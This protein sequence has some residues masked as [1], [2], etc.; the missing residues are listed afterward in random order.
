MNAENRSALVLGAN[1]GQADLIRYLGEQGWTVTAC[2][3]RPGGAGAKLAHDFRL[4][5]ITDVKGV[6]ALARELGVDL[7]YSVS[8][9]M[10]VPAV[11]GASV[12]LGLPHYFDPALVALLDDKAALR[13][14]LNAN[15]LSVVPFVKA[16]S[17]E[18]CAGWTSYPCMVKPADA[19]GQRGV[20]KVL[21]PEG[22]EAALANAISLSP[23]GTAIVEA[24]LEG[25]EISYN[26]LVA[27][28]RVVVN[29]VSERLVHGDHLVGVPRGHLIPPVAVD[30]EVCAQ[31][32]ALVEAVTAMLKVRDGTLYFQMKVTTEGPRIIEIAPRLDGCH[33]WRLMKL[34]REVDFLD[35]AVRRLEGEEV[36]AAAAGVPAKGVYELMFQQ[37]APGS[38]FQASDFPKPDDA[39]YHEYR[40][41]DG[42]TILP[43]NGRLEVVGYYVRKRPG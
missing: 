27:D 25:V 6:T 37:A 33:I 11:V 13:A 22:F 4:Q 3:H 28:G 38:I 18:D 23:S 2:A 34:A 24:W 10:A 9:D 30:A 41:E 36:A 32:A 5:D 39:L 8:S 19:Q 20:A 29:E 21:S 7:V 40:Y 17:M 1:A 35:L 43:I 16:R 31:G 26:V 12:A 42:E 15:N 14:Q